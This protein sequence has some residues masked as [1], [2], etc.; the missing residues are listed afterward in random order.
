M[1]VLTLWFHAH[2]VI[3]S[4]VLP[5]T[6]MRGNYASPS[7]RDRTCTLYACGER[8]QLLLVCCQYDVSSDRAV[9]VTRAIFRETCPKHVSGTR[10]A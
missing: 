7:L 2:Q 8:G 3:G 4:C 10:L 9:A 1:R 5:E 6:A